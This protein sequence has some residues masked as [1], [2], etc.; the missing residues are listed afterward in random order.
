MPA[1]SRR[2]FIQGV[3]ASALGVSLLGNAR[4]R[5][6]EPI[7]DPMLAAE[8][9][10]QWEC[11]GFL[12]VLYQWMH[13][14]AQ[15]LIP[16][17]AVVDWYV[18]DFRPLRPEPAVSTGVRFIPWTWAVNGKTYP[19]TAE[20]SFVQRFGDGTVL[21]DVVRLVW[22]G[23][24]RWFFG[25]TPEFVQQQIDRF[26]PRYIPA[27]QGTVPFGLDTVIEQPADILYVLPDQIG[28][29]V[30]QSAPRYTTDP[31]DDAEN[32]MIVVYHDPRNPVAT[33]LAAVERLKTGISIRQAIERRLYFAA[34]TAGFK[35]LAW[36][37]SPVNGVPYAHYH[38]EGT[39]EAG[40]P[41]FV[42]WGHERGRSLLTISALRRDDLLTMASA[43]IDAAT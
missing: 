33:G 14:D 35:V 39:R 6:G 32:M 12:D 24:W 15:A 11:T 31:P 38:A 42:T 34:R 27:P 29:G 5:A 30:Q 25:R 20:V 41:E 40:T 16:L 23:D 17:Y 9:L 7:A 13:P 26:S 28:I 18:E 43:L 3:A 10:S 19:D 37:L 2:V 22:E 36:N 21:E 8:R 1:F 4:I